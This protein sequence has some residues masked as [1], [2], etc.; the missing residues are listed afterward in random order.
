MEKHKIKRKKESIWDQIFFTEEFG[1]AFIPE[2]VRPKIRLYLEKAGIYK[3]PYDKFGILFYITLG[4]TTFSYIYLWNTFV[5]LSPI[6]LLIYTFVF[7]FGV[8]G[9]LALVMMGLVYAY[10]DVQIFQRTSEMENVLADFLSIFNDNL[11]T[12]MTMDKALWRAIKPEFGVL[13]N[14]IKIAS[15]RVMTGEDVVETLEDF[16]K[17][18]DSITLKRAFSLITE[19]MHGGGKLSDVIERVIDDI[20]KTTV[21]KERMIANSISYT[22]FI[23]IIVVGISPGLF[24]LSY[25]LLQMIDTFSQNVLTTAT[26]SSVMGNISIA[27][28]LTDFTL[29]SKL[30]LSTIS[31]FAAMIISIINK[32]DI[33]GG[34]KYIP[35]FIAGSY[36]VYVTLMAIFGWAFSSFLTSI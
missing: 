30:A 34:L 26:L 1:K 23:S 21:L 28:K 20:K 24:A 8:L 10:I 4:I 32:G 19:S 33:R 7:W 15:K 9:I 17:K 3:I 31:F 6:K 12:G 35:M 14:E 2:F 29:F 36:T 13:S 27:I 16:V 11:K 5:Q 22:I 18:Y 25:Y